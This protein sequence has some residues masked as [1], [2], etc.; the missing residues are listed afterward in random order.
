MKVNVSKTQ[1][2]LIN[3]S[4]SFDAS[5]YIECSDGGEVRSKGEVLK[6]LGFSFDS[7]PTVRAQ[8]A[9]IQDK[10]R[11]RLWI[12][13]HLKTFGFEQ[14][15]LVQVYQSQIRS[16]IEYCSVVYHGLLTGEQSAQLEGLQY[17]ALKCVY[18][19][20]ESYRGLREKAGIETL[21]ERR[22]KAVDK[23]AVKCLNGGFSAWFPLNEGTRDTRSKRKYKEFHARCDRL[24]NTPIYCM[25]RRLN[26]L[27][28]NLNTA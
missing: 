12:L 24:R 23:F 1:M 28:K 10:V 15:E 25:R 27:E 20:G 19:Y 18:G 21:E 13:R 11:R 2:L 16:V 8:V 4:V 9:A 26:E 6:L 7:T 22:R 14:D 5:A 17:K 3:D